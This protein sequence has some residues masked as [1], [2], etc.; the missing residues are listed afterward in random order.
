[1]SIFA[2]VDARR[3]D[4][5]TFLESGGLIRAA[6]LED[7]NAA[8][9]IAAERDGGA[10]D[11]HRLAMMAFLGADRAQ[12]FIA[13][14]AG[15]VVGF[16]KIAYLT[17][18]ADAHGIP[19]GWYLGGVVVRPSNRRRGVGRALTGGRIE[20]LRSRT[21]T[22]YYFASAQNEVTIDLHRPF[23]FVEVGR[24]IVVPGVSFTGG[25]GVLF[26]LDLPEFDRRD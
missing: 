26:R 20:W 25:V 3:P 7:L 19:E 12:L 2:N 9:E 24:G 11:R 18:A 22:V 4:G 1:M 23:G 15:D 13:E 10:A 14:L 17:A 8:A 16:G 21:H 5:P 6:T